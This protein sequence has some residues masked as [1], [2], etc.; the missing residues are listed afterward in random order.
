MN[1]KVM[2]RPMFKMGG[3][4]TPRINYNVGAFGT[5]KTAT[6]LGDMSFKDLLAMQEIGNQKQLEGLNSMRDINKLSAI[7]SLATN[8]LPNITRGGFKGVSDF[9]KDPA[10]ITAALTGLAGEKKIDLK[11]DEIKGKQ[12][13]KYISGRA[14]SKQLDIAEKK[15]LVQTATQ[16][17][18]QAAEDSQQLLIDAGGSIENMN[19]EQKIKFRDLRTLLGDL[20]PSKAQ[21]LAVAAVEKRNA[22]AL[23]DDNRVLKGKEYID[24]VRFLKEQFLKGNFASGGRVD[25]QMGTPMMGEQ[26]MQQE[27]MM[28]EQPMQQENQMAQAAVQQEGEEDPYKYLRDRLPPEIPDPVVRLIAYNKEAFND[29]ASI[30]AQ[31]DVDQFNQKYNVELVVNV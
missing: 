11:A 23:E 16:L 26:P 19:Q 5:S 7:G 12:F 30:E 8:V 22:A 18:L 10:T 13:D 17:K 15:A 31:D 2:N 28:V 20:S 24:A 29:F 4:T 9:L 1:Y 6:E 3:S 25:R 27:A 21:Q 14:T